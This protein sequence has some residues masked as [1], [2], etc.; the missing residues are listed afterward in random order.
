MRAVAALGRRGRRWG[1]RGLEETR[2]RVGSGLGR[3]GFWQGGW[4]GTSWWLGHCFHDWSVI[5][6]PLPHPPLPP[7]NFPHIHHHLLLLNFL[8]R[9]R[10]R[11]IGR[12]G[13]FPHPVHNHPFPPPIPILPPTP[14]PML[15]ISL[16]GTILPTAF[17]LYFYLV[18]IC[19]FLP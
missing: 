10:P 11:Y 9:P 13:P 3:T 5:L 15:D 16:A 8:L 18:D 17:T 1:W 4:L 19:H 6:L 12:P 14:L 7:H 2:W